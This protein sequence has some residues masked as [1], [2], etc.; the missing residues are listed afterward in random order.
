M[1]RQEASRPQQA[2]QK[3]NSPTGGVD[4]FYG[5]DVRATAFNTPGPLERDFSSKGLRPIS[6]PCAGAEERNLWNLLKAPSNDLHSILTRQAVIDTL[7]DPGVDLRSLQQA[8]VEAYSLHMHLEHIFGVD[9]E[10]AERAQRTG[11]R[12][13]SRIEMV[14]SSGINDANL[15]ERLKE[16]KSTESYNLSDQQETVYM[17]GQIKND[18]PKICAFSKKLLAVPNSTV[19]D[20][21]IELG[22]AV[23]AL[24]AISGEGLLALWQSKE[25]DILESLRR[26]AEGIASMTSQIGAI[27]GFAELALRDGFARA[28][29]DTS[30]PESYQGAWSFL[31]EKNGHQASWRDEADVA[32][33]ITNNSPED[34]ALTILSGS[35]MSGKS[36]YMT[37]TLY[38]HL[39]A[40]A[41]GYVPAQKG[42]FHVYDSFVCLD[43]ASAATTRQLSAFGSEVANWRTALLEQC[44]GKTFLF[45]DESF[46]TTSPE[47]QFKLLLGTVRY[48]GG[49]GIRA[50][51]ANHNEEFLQAM[52]ESNQCRIYH[53]AAAIT[54]K[55]GINFDYRLSPGVEES[56]ALVVARKMGFPE[57]VIAIA[58]EYL[59]GNNETI[60]NVPCRTKPIER[61]T[62]EER[63]L[64]KSKANSFSI[65][66]PAA[67]RLIVAKSRSGRRIGW[68]KEIEKREAE[69]IVRDRWLRGDDEASDVLQRDEKRASP[70]Q[71]FFSLHSDDGDF[72]RSWRR[73]IGIYESQQQREEFIKTF[74]LNGASTDSRTVLERQKMFSELAHDGSLYQ[75][76]A[77]VTELWD[78]LW[79]VDQVHDRFFENFF[80]GM[81]ENAA[82]QI[83]IAYGEEVKPACDFLVA[84]VRFQCRLAGIK[85]EETSAGSIIANF[86][87]ID[88]LT[89]EAADL[90]E[91]LRRLKAEKE[92]DLSEQEIKHRYDEVW[93]DVCEIGGVESIKEKTFISTSGTYKK[94][95]R[96]L[97]AQV[98]KTVRPANLLEVALDELSEHLVEF[99]DVFDRC[100]KQVFFMM[101][102]GLARIKALR[103]MVGA[104]DV[105]E[106]FLNGLRSVDSVY[107][108]QLANYFEELLNAGLGDLRS[109]QKL[110]Q[111]CLE[112]HRKKEDNAIESHEEAP[113]AQA[114]Q[115]YLSVMVEE[116]NRLISLYE[117]AK[118]VHSGLLCKVEFNREGSVNIRGG[119]NPMDKAEAQV[120]NSVEQGRDVPVQLISGS[121][122][123]GKTYYLK[124]L[125]WNFLMA[126][127]LGYVAA[128]AASLPLFDRVV[129]LDRVSHLKDINLSAFG[130]EVEYWREFIKADDTGESIFA[131]IDEAFSTTSPRYQSALSY[132]VAVYLVRRGNLVAFASHNHD[133]IDR[134]LDTNSNSARAYH[135]ETH[136]DEEDQ[137]CFDY[138]L[139]PGHKQSSALEVARKLKLPE[140]I[141]RFAE[142]I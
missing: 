3:A 134:F 130:N 42:N 23:S 40:Q 97:V 84:A 76:R 64:L 100:M 101:P 118:A 133:F 71:S 119:F 8:K 80:E 140:E 137:I 67:D 123:S 111:F 28:T 125:T 61:F 70:V 27:T 41:F 112:R 53:F 88:E 124:M 106:Q 5:Q 128:E 95:A 120:R 12:A 18:I 57:E 11:Q 96:D 37:A 45:G 69:C 52:G 117:L 90:T 56:H 22:E 115:G 55:G 105:V 135:F 72:N 126:Q 39:C 116:F 81:L 19:V 139:S 75:L 91:A 99:D 93:Q 49:H 36:F 6:I 98:S 141:V 121:N 65:F 24:P 50:M 78:H 79:A 33:Q 17:L 10:E 26:S 14:V 4:L 113:L 68:K 86:G 51:M 87:R 29:F 38:E 1:G 60:C 35:N 48:L 114:G 47:D 66:V 122:M 131:A 107:L 9:T 54:D 138:K 44:H 136:F 34:T 73:L 74:I 59:K 63:N 127:S 132:A 20:F 85:V 77:Q 62:E 21:G 102:E 32:P 104:E 43:R 15:N 110:F 108:H 109:G 25:N 16:I 142:L 82:Q 30:E 58:E 31:Y 83:E 13:R 92:C 2:V 129:Y 7:I 103:S 89:K 46:S 94:L